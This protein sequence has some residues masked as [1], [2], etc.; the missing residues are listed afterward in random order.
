[1]TTKEPPKWGPTVRTA[2]IDATMCLLSARDVLPKARNSIFLDPVCKWYLIKP[3]ESIIAPIEIAGSVL[4]G[5]GQTL[6]C[7]EKS[8]LLERHPWDVWY[9]THRDL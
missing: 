5:F 9:S 2:R 3:Y 6:R 4:D 7:V 1:M 8:E